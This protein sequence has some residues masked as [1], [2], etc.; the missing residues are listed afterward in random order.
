VV[1]ACL[2]L[3]FAFPEAE[4]ARRLGLL[5]LGAG[6]HLFLD[7][8]Q[9][10]AGPGGYSWFFPFSWT[11]WQAGLFWPDQT[12]LALPALVGLVAAME[13]LRRRGRR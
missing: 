11:R 2:L 3:A 6:L 4:R 5:A 9:A 8:L 10:S 13:L 12:T 1:L 7:L